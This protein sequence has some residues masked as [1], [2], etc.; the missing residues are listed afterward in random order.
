MSEDHSHVLKM[1]CSLCRKPLVFVMPQYCIDPFVTVCQDC[2][3]KIDPAQR[4]N[5]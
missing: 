1:L 4:G 5:P 2:Y 3:K